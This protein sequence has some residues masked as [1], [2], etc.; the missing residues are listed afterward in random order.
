MLPE[1]ANSAP[2]LF[3]A[4]Q[5]M[6]N[7]DV[8]TTTEDGSGEMRSR[9]SQFIPTTRDAHLEAVDL[10]RR[11]AVAFRTD[12]RALERTISTPSKLASTASDLFSRG[13]STSA[14]VSAACRYGILRSCVR[15]GIFKQRNSAPL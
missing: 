12:V 11:K 1:V 4:T 5:V 14:Q 13:A 15:L 6:A 2:S 7:W 3:V 8:P 9:F 10:L